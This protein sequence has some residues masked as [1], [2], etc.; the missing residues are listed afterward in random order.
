MCVR[1]YVCER[2]L[3]LA[4]CWCRACEVLAPGVRECPHEPPQLTE[5]SPECTV[6][7]GTFYVI[8]HTAR[9]NWGPVASADFLR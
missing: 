9:M 2:G 1:V 3:V 5:V 4:Q 7:C 8:G 6:L